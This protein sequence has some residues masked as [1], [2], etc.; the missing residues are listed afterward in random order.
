MEPNN[1]QRAAWAGEALKAFFRQVTMT[2][3]EDPAEGEPDD[4]EDL[5]AD[6]ITDLLHY[7]DE[8][9]FDPDMLMARAMSN[10]CAEVSED[11]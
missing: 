2:D 3:L 6:L 11:E 9:G 1:E 5:V 10:Y 4:H 8:H 7:A